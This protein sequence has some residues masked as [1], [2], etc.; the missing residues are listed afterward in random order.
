GCK[1]RAWSCNAHEG[2]GDL[3]QRPLWVKSG[4]AQSEQTLSALPPKADMAGRFMNTRPNPNRSESGFLIQPK[5]LFRLAS[6]MKLR[7]AGERSL[8][9]CAVG[10]AATQQAASQRAIFGQVCRRVVAPMSA[11]KRPVAS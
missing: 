5:G 9:R 7:T 11:A 2:K 10:G 6:A 4:K 1:R 3:A 8:R